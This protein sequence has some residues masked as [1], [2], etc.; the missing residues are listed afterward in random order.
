LFAD[1]QIL[2]GL[3]LGVMNIVLKNFEYSS[4]FGF[5]QPGL[6]DEGFDINSPVRTER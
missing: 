1:F 5:N 3:Y 2:N 6:L 4:S